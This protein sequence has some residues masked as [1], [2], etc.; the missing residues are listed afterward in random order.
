METQF[1]EETTTSNTT[2]TNNSVT[3]VTKFSIPHW[4]DMLAFCIAFLTPL[5][6]TMLAIGFLLMIDFFTGMWAAYKT[7]EKITS[8]KM[9]TTV[10]KIILYNIAII[11][12]SVCQ[13]Y[14]VPQ[15]PFVSIIAGCVTII[16]IKS[17]SENIL[18]AT[19]LDLWSSL[20]EFF[21][22]NKTK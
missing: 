17:F 16:E 20:K 22:R 3:P 18:K 15:I 5:A 1:L 14:L 2:V 19:G 4:P 10:S 9:G 6:P 13:K 8:I 12:G 11:T 7:G 21:I